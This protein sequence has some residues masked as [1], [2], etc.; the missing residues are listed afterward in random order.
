[1]NRDR[2]A[3]EVELRALEPATLDAVA[4]A[5]LA[6][7]ARVVEWRWERLGTSLGLGTGGLFRVHGTASLAG[8]TPVPWSAVLKVLHP[9]SGTRHDASAREPSHWA[10][11]K[12]EPLA[13]GSN[14]LASLPG[15]LT[16]PRCLALAER[17]DDI[18][19]LWLEEVVDRYGVEWDAWPRSRHLLA[20]Y[21]LGRFN[22]AYLA[23][24]PLPDRPWLGRHYLRQ[25]IEQTDTTG[26]LPL[27]DDAATWRH[28]L[29]RGVFPPDTQD[30]LLRLWAHRHR[31]L[32]AL[33]HLPQ[34]LRHG[35]AHRSNLFARLG[36]DGAEVTTAIDWGTLG[37]GPVGSEL[38]LSA[39]G[40]FAATEM[41][42]TGTFDVVERL[43]ERYAAG[44]RDAKWR[45]DSRLARLGFAATT[46]LTGASLLHW[47]L[48][49]LLDD[50]C[51][52]EF[53]RGAATP[54]A[55]LLRREAALTRCLL[56]LGDESSR[57]LTRV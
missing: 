5:A 44:L 35:D 11:W 55:D 10:Y 32:D 42:A 12:R 3:I 47:R 30:L 34:T 39:L 29:L 6:A 41:E 15:R 14:L 49:R 40:R 53:L 2:E 33:D 4:G 43:F 20:A 45:G 25:R 19:W 46:A 31:L 18:V 48:Q 51:R 38:T 26:G 23:G 1:M 36:P 28:T 24:E 8:G 56:A 22:G 16:A 27:F 54:A 9:P 13:Y 7:A 50:T 52:A 21:H 57:L 37:I 17:G